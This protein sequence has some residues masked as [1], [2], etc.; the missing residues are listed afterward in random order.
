MGYRLNRLDEPV[1]VA[2]PK[3]M[4]TEFGIHYRLESCELP[5]LILVSSKAERKS[6]GPHRLICPTSLVSL[7]FQARTMGFSAQTLMTSKPRDF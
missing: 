3:P 7:N 4:Q 6:W 2:V 1:L 5:Q